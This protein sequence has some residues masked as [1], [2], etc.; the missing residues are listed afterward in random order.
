[1]EGPPGVAGVLPRGGVVSIAVRRGVGE[2]GVGV[3]VG[4]EI[5]GLLGVGVDGMLG[6]NS[7]E[8]L[9]DD[10]LE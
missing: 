10:D 8:T 2:G 1:M 3:S 7:A 9:S 4:S 6:F 5:L